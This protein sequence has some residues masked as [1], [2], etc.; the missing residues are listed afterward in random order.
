MD[1]VLLEDSS[2]VLAVGLGPVINFGIC[3]W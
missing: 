3:L 2:L 1:W